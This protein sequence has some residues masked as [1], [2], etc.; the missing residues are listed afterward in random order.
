VFE[1]IDH[2]PDKGHF[3]ASI[4]KSVVPEAGG[5]SGGIGFP[6]GRVG[7]MAE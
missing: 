6:P 3:A 2:M 4:N 7:G 1:I 5:G